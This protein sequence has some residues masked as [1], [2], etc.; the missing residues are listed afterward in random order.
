MLLCSAASPLDRDRNHQISFLIPPYPCVYLPTKQEPFATVWREKEAAKEARHTES[1]RTQIKFPRWL[2]SHRQTFVSMPILAAFPP[3]SVVA[4]AAPAPATAQIA[5]RALPLGAQGEGGQVNKETTRPTKKKYLPTNS[6]TAQES[7]G[8]LRNQVRFSSSPP[9][10]E[11]KT[12]CRP[13][14]RRSCA[15][16][17]ASA[18]VSAAA[19]EVAKHAQATT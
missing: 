5:A 19:H 9:S 4:A 11:R 18:A 1:E 12:T 6:R 15:A 3:H 13:S 16:V 14:N 10:S 17:A 2:L 8:H 7:L